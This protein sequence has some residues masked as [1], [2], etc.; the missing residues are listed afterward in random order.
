MGHYVCLEMT[1][2]LGRV[3]IYLDNCA[4]SVVTY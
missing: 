1:D 3:Q 2:G 4:N